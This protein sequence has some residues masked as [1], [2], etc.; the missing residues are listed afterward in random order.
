MILFYEYSKS[1]D[2]LIDY[3]TQVRY[4]RSKELQA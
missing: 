3:Q 2:Q 4:F 1:L